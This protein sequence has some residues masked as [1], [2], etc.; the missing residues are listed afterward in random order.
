MTAPD[1]HTSP[2]GLD[3]ELAVKLGWHPINVLPHKPDREP[4]FWSPPSESGEALRHPPPFSS[5]WEW[6]GHF[7]EAMKELGWGVVFD[8]FK[9]SYWAA[10]GNLA[11]PPSAPI[12]QNRADTG[13]LAIARAALKALNGEDDGN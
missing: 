2:R 9:G 8:T 10:F 12:G 4:D 13:P 11:G 1:A 7:I 6:A 3:A 5:T